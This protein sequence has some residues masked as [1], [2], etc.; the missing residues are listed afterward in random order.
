MALI[1]A[2]AGG[3]S[4]VN[5]AT[6]LFKDPKDAERFAKIDAAY[7]LAVQGNENALAYLKQAT[8]QFGVVYVP[9]YGNT[10]GFASPEAKQ[11]ALVKWNAAKVQLGLQ[12]VVVDVTDKLGGVIDKAPPAVQETLKDA[13]QT[14]ARSSGYEILPQWVVWGG[15]ALVAWL[16]L[17]PKAGGA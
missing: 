4:L 17:R 8:G 13:A 1:G 7:A 15:L 14:A 11:Y 12:G 5:T 10:G 6:A 2:I 9:G 3:I 16:A